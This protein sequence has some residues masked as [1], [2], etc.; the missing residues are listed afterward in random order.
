MAER[1]PGQRHHQDF[2]RHADQLADA[3]K[4][5]PAFALGRIALPIDIPIPLHLAIPLAVEPAILR[6]RSLQ[7]GA[8]DVHRRI[9]EIFDAA[10]VVEIEMR[11]NDVANIGGRETEVFDLSQ[12]GIRLA[13]PDTIGNSKK[14]A[15]PSRLRHVAHA[16]PGVDE[17]QP[18][19]GLDQQAMANDLGGSENRVMPVP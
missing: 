1:V 14:R 15:E 4:A 3:R 2:G 7:L 8:E 17:H 18:D 11:Q 9:R 13:Q 19:F 6:S 12:S 16:E 5:E 10:G